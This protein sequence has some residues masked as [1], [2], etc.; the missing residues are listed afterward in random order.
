MEDTKQRILKKSLEL[1]STKGYDAVSVGEIAKAVGIKAPSLYNH[2]P[3]KQAIFDAIVESTAAHYEKDTGRINI[4]VQNVKQDC[5]TFSHISEQALADKIRQ[6]FLYSLHDKQVSQFRRM[7]T[8]EQFRSPELAALFSERYVD[9]MISYHA[10]IFRSLIAGG[11]IRDEDPDTLAW[12]YVSPVITLLSVCDR[13]PEREAESLAKLDAHVKLFFRTFN[14]ERDEKWILC[15]IC[16]AKTQCRLRPCRNL[17]RVFL[18]LCIRKQFFHRG[19]K[20]L[21]NVHRQ[22]QGWVVLPFFKVDNGFPAHPDQLGQLHLLEIVPLPV[23]FQFCDQC[24]AQ[25][26]FSSIS[27][28]AT[29]RT[30]SIRISVPI[31]Q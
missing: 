1:F 8:L 22:L 24:H 13:Q 9:C 17:H 7:M 5:P 6:I 2:F 18:I 14:I 27:Q 30:T 31:R 11:E 12:M 10:G 19:V 4:H 16:G 29:V 23:F 3:S 15:L 20:D 21:C 25:S 28:N 26:P